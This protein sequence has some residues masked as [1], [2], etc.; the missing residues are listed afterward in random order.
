MDQHPH[1]ARRS[2]L[3]DAGISYAEQR[4]RLAR[5][6]WT[7]PV[8]GVLASGRCLAIDVAA[9]AVIRAG[10]GAALGG[11]AAAELSL[12]RN[13]TLP[14]LVLVA[15]G[16]T[17]PD[18]QAARFRQ[19]RVPF[20]AVDCAGLPVTRPD[21]TAAD[22]AADVRLSEADR[23]A[24]VTGLIQRGLTTPRAFAEAAA[25]TPRQVRRQVRRL[26]EES[27]AGAHSGPEAKFWRDC[28]DD[29]RL[30]VPL[31]NHPLG[32]DGEPVEHGRYYLDGYIRELR[33]GYEVQ[34]R[35]HHAD[36]WV[37]DTTRLGDIL[38][39]HGIVLL[40][41]LVPDIEHQQQRTLA[42]WE[43]FLRNRSREL[44]VPMPPFVPPPT[45]R[46]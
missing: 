1:I 10:R 20:E 33:A 42:R 39:D 19:T 36:T 24:L 41:L 2:E 38:V 5:G 43:A 35:T 27:L 29:A 14:V 12:A 11:R 32:R 37:A 17:I 34:S 15:S 31:L 9:A 45:W 16:V 28:V 18:S 21:R 8:A 4:R 23:R 44:G 7:A 40:P 6:E 22:V 3:R 26:V 46:P 13:P 25:H 30:P